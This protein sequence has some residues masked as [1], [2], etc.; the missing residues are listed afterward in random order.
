MHP[1]IRRRLGAVATVALT[2]GLAA[3]P[4]P[5]VAGHGPGGP[6][7]HQLAAGQAEVSAREAEVQRAAEQL[8]TARAQLERLAGAAEVAVEAYDAARVKE[9]AA[10]D[11]VQ[12]ARLVVSAAQRRVAAAERRVGRFGA[13]AYESG[14]MSAVESMLTA[15]GPESMVY[16]VG[17]LQ[18][19][20]DSERNASQA[21][22]AARV[23]EVAVERQ[24][25]ATLRAASAAA[26]AAS[27]AR[28]RAQAAVQ[29]QS[30]STQAMQQRRQQLD[31]L[32]ADAKAHASALERAHLAAIARQQARRAARAAAAAAAAAAAQAE[33]QQQTTTPTPPPVTSGPPPD[34]TGTVSAAKGEQAVHYAESQIGKPYQWGAAGPDT[35]DCSGL[36]MW[37]YSQVDVH[38]LHYTGYQWEEGVHI[39][40]SS[41]R[42]GDLVFFA[43]D[44]SDP[45]TIHHVGMFIGSGEMVEAPY[46]G[47]NVRISSIYRSDLI[48][49]V[50]PYDR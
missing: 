5:A 16:R 21:V 43:T 7:A 19:I 31:Q 22:D 20:S 10:Q 37:A 14:G 39:P 1:R 49:A 25:E 8:A 34:T 27:N 46:T 15:T 47:A 26:A 23:Y 32:L 3:V 48:G 44:T 50:R 40:I 38:L 36:T 29:Q 4:V 45:N 18:A 35:Y 12:A 42:P 2:A 33:Q 6:S 30:A 13:A 9:Q 11:A 41:L 28:D 17:A 24:A